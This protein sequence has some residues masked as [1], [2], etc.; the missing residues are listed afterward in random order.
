MPDSEDPSPAAAREAR[1]GAERA[2]L[3]RFADDAEHGGDLRARVLRAQHA[4]ADRLRETAEGGRQSF[5][6][7]VG[8][9]SY[10]YQRYDLRRVDC[11]WLQ[12]VHGLHLPQRAADGVFTS[13]GMGAIA[14]VAAT[15]ARR[16]WA[17]VEISPDPYF[18]VPWLVRRLHPSLTLA[19]T[20]V[21]GAGAAVVWLDTISSAWPELPS[22]RGSAQLLVIDTTCLEPDSPRIAAWLA[23]ADELGLTT[24]LVRS[25]IKLDCFGH[26]IGRLGSTI[27]VAPTLDPSGVD[28]LASDIREAVSLLG[29]TVE[30]ARIYP[31]LGD[32][33]FLDLAR[34]RTEAIRESTRRLAGELGRRLRDRDDVTVLPRAHETAV[35]VRLPPGTTATEPSL[36]RRVADLC[37]RSGLPVVAAGSFG[38]DRIAVTD[39]A[40]LRDGHHYLRVCGSDVADTVDSA[41]AE[42]IEGALT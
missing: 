7:P 16:D 17:T 32:P 24:I 9:L 26:E 8:T 28:A 11:D 15:L 27:V 36:A 37:E 39:Y 35:L 6:T 34:W 29:V 19:E 23:R 18:E 14:A 20:P 2:L 31:W 3:E 21:F 30:P 41:V 10:S 25:H 12:V 40:D 1:Q 33:A 22:Q 4:W 38:L 5:S 13:S 42:A